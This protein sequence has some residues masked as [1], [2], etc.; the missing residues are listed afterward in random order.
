[1]PLY[2]YF[3]FVLCQW[4]D[5]PNDLYIFI[6]IFFYFVSVSLCFANVLC[7]L[8]CIFS[9]VPVARF[10]Q[11]S[12]PLNLYFSL[13]SV[14]WFCQYSMPLYLYFSFVPVARFQ[15]SMPLY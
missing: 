11:F 2:L 8:I 6:F 1:M 13:V 10:C 9:F 15:C 5:F 12:M 14:A 7:L 4:L 3:S